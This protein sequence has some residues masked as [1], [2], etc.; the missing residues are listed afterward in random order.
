MVH[1]QGNRVT[2]FAGQYAGCSW[3]GYGTQANDYYNVQHQMGVHAMLT[4]G[5]IPKAI[6]NFNRN[7][8]GFANTDLS[9]W[10]EST[11]STTLPYRGII[12][13]FPIVM[14]PVG[15]GYVVKAVPEGFALYSDLPAADMAHVFHAIAQA[16]IV[17]NP[18]RHDYDALDATYWEMIFGKSFIPAGTEGPR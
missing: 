16:I 8:V 13:N 6:S 3:G 11:R 14:P 10:A 12:G 17:N 9:N 18:D 1:P 7:V 15:S 5:D 4:K 2:M